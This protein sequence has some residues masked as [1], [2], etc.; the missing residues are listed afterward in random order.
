MLMVASSRVVRF[1]QLIILAA[2]VSLDIGPTTTA[3][4]GTEEV[5]AL[6]RQ[7]IDL[8]KEGKF[9]EALPLFEKLN[10]LESGNPRTLEGLSYCTLQHAAT[11]TDTA[12]RKTERAR[13]RKLADQAKAAGDNSNLL[14][15]ILD[16]PEDGSEES[17]S[18]HADVDQFMKAGEAAYAKGDLDGAAENYRQALALDP[19]E[20]EAALFL[21]D[22]FF[23]E[24]EHEEAGRWF[25]RAIEI[26]PNKETAYRYWG[27]DLYAQG[28]Q[29]EAKN[30]FVQAVVAQPYD[31]RSWMGLIQWAQKQNVILSHP[32]IQ[33]PG[34]VEFDAKGENGKSQTNIILD[35]SGLDGP[36]KKD[37]K[38]AWISY[39]MERVLWHSD[40]FKQQFPNE[41][42]YRHSLAEEVGCYQA[43]VSVVREFLQKKNE[44]KELDP[45][46]ASLLKLADDGILEPF[47]LIS[48]ADA[49][50]AADYPAF[51]DAHRDL[52]ARYIEKWII[53]SA[54]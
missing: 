45:A 27:D 53:H 18:S 5:A 40:R 7:A 9:V 13:A 35:P 43:V 32:A 8:Y 51:R 44:I 16:V 24:K 3:S 4:Q 11:L 22:V 20:Y 28:Q 52:V 38:S 36:A 21:G 19:K 6:R 34:R 50:I 46:L 42:V 2:F 48:K 12:A 31:K 17:F 15:L 23:K 54:K 25:L 47:V 26:D 39:S 10:S 30:K 33:P 49:G 29:N 14:K 41:K 1:T 37:G